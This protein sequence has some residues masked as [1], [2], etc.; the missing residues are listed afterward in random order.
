[1][2]PI[3]KTAALSILVVLF[4][5]GRLGAQDV[6]PLPPDIAAPAL[7][8]PASN[9][10]ALAAQAEGVPQ[11]TFLWEDF[12]LGFSY[13]NTHFAGS[14]MSGGIIAPDFPSNGK[15]SFRG[16]FDFPANGGRAAFST[17]QAGDFTGCTAITLDI[18]NSS[19]LSFDG[20]LVF[21]QGDNWTWYQSGHL[22]VNP[23]WNKNVTFRVKQSTENTAPDDPIIHM[24]SLADI[25]E[26]AFVFDSAQKGEGYLYIDNIRLTGANPNKVSSV[27]PEDQAV[28]TEVLISGFEDG[29]PLFKAETYSGSSASDVQVIA[30]QTTQGT[31]LA[32]MSYV[33]TNP[34]D[35]APFTLE[36][37]LDLT[38]TTGCRFDVYNP[39]PDEVE[40]ELCFS[41]G[42]GYVYFESTPQTLKPGWNRDVTFP[43]RSQ[44]YKCEATGW[45]NNSYVFPMSQIRKMSLTFL[46]HQ[47]IS[48]FFAV[49]NVRFIT[50]DP[51]GLKKNLD[52]A[53]PPMAP[54]TGTDTLLE[55][56]EKGTTTWGADTADSAA[57]AATIIATKSATEG[58]HMLR[59]DFD[60]GT[61]DKSAFFGFE[62]DMNLDGSSAVKVDI[63][64]PNKMLLQAD[65]ALTLG[66]NY[67]W[68]ESKAFDLKPGWNR[69]VTFNLK[70]KNYK[71]ALSEWKY[72]QLPTPLAKLKKL[73]IGFYSHSPGKGTIYMDNVRVT[74]MSSAAMDS[75]KKF[76]P[77]VVNGRS[78]VWDSLTSTAGGWA[79]DLS[80][81]DNS[82][83]LGLFYTRF[84]GLNAIEMQYQTQSP[85]QT[86]D[87]TKTQNLDWTSV[88]GVKFDVY[89]PENYPMEMDMAFK[90]GP[91]MDWYET[92]RVK[93]M[94]GWNKG[95]FIDLSV[96]QMKSQNSNWAATEYLTPQDDIREAIF[97]VFPNRAATGSVL[98]TNLRTIER[99]PLGAIGATGAGQVVG[100]TSKTILTG[101]LSQYTLME[102]F[103]NYK[104]T[105][106]QSSTGVASIST[107]YATDGAHSLKFDY[108][109][110]G[111]GIP[112]FQY[113]VPGAFQNLTPY[114]RMTF[115][116]Y[117][118]NGPVT[119]D[120][121]FQTTATNEWEESQSVTINSGWNKGL[122]IQLI[123]NNFKSSHT[124]WKY[125]DT[126]RNKAHVDYLNF[127][128]TAPPGRGTI[129]LD[130]I[131]LSGNTSSP[132]KT[133]GILSEE[134]QVKI[135]P[136]DD[137]QLVLGGKVTQP[138]NASSA[139]AEFT[140][141][142]LD[143]RGSVNQLTLSTGV[144]LNS[145]DD[146]LQLFT[147]TQLGSQEFGIQDS[148]HWRSTILQVAG[149]ENYA[150]TPNTL[151]NTAGYVA[152]LRQDIMKEATVGVGLVDERN[153]NTVGSNPFSANVESD[154][155]TYE[156]DLKAEIPQAHLN[157]QAEV[158][159]SAY[160]E[161]SGLSYGTTSPN[162]NAY[163]FYAGFTLGAFKLDGSF[164]QEDMGFFAPYSTA[165]SGGYSKYM[166]DLVWQVDTFQP[167]KSLMNTDKMWA[168]FLENTT[169]ELQY[170]GYFHDPA[171]D[172]YNNTDLRLIIKNNTYKSALFFQTWIHWFDEGNN[173]GDPALANPALSTHALI[174]TINQDLLYRIS[175][176]FFL[177]YTFRYNFTDYWEQWTNEGG[178]K[179][180][181]WGDTWLTANIKYLTQ[182]GS[183]TGQ[184]TNIY[185]NLDKRLVG[186][187]VEAY[188]TYGV[189]C[190]ANYWEDDNNLQTVNMFSFGVNGKF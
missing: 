21:K 162:N 97:Q 7:P 57:T 188:M 79:A 178:F 119:M 141:A 189:P 151:G 51:V 149:F 107:N 127:K 109:V 2:K 174:Q 63:Y 48:S 99:D 158:A 80:A 144:P 171:I 130:N 50:M 23:G 78:V 154:I 186:N 83:A 65:L 72:S 6:P 13:W 108:T 49:D 170:F 20:S 105:G 26:V 11:T 104:G 64:N 142:Q 10:G 70:T 115:D 3:L 111:G 177:N 163:Y 150:D 157:F 161:Y 87:F 85:S 165:G 166:G 17:D 123:G 93:L 37:D 18:Y 160:D 100:A 8:A 47:I 118:P 53:F 45:R 89:N 185:L 168:D 12:E 54:I 40:V 113:T 187:A 42:P 182:D 122:A 82:F 30:A 5:L 92:P 133:D 159:Q 140:K 137:V 190:F 135:N 74:G 120:V 22:K 152:R 16:H 169:A 139:T 28:G 153:G 156:A 25:R 129:Y 75:L 15:Y 55:G 126:L 46:P 34:D 35:K 95:L 175:P 77:H 136:S 67:Q 145:T 69:D 147:G 181:F 60:M 52:D 184:F 32:K 172:T 143:V 91:T 106:A 124:D 44:T 125:W 176:Q 58:T 173:A 117:N 36:G 56:F 183:W 88:L 43:L 96:P 68:F 41:T 24:A 73:Y 114:N 179:L 19:T 121:A 14:V 101:E 38:K 128:I 94:P 103:E 39:L 138:V 9:P 61:G 102:S 90:T 4:P 31:H 110:Y 146:P 81:N 132:T 76:V 98:L 180:R 167:I 155:K 131:Q 59:G 29:N 71:N 62:G 27:K 66:D 134:L 116:V 1:M 148:V 86:A 84:Q 112:A 33:N 164:L